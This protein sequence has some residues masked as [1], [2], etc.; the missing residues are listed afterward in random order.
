MIKTSE[1]TLRNLFGLC[2]YLFNLSYVSMFF[3]QMIKYDNKKF[4]KAESQIKH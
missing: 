1:T 2:F 4:L 3:S